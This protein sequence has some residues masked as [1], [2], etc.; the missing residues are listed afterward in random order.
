MRHTNVVLTVAAAALLAAC[1][2]SSDSPTTPTIKPGANI[3]SGNLQ[4]GRVT[5]ALAAPLVV[6]VADANGVPLTGQVVRFIIVSGG[7]LVDTDSTLTNSSGQATARWSLG[8]SV[9]DSQR[10]VAKLGA[11]RTTATTIGMFKATAQPGA[12]QLAAVSGGGQV[13]APSSVLTDSL[14]AR[15]ADQYGNPIAGVLVVWSTSGSGAGVLSPTQGTS[16]ANGYVRAKWTLGSA[17]GTQTASAASTGRTTVSFL[18][19]AQTVVVPPGLSMTV[20]SPLANALAGD[21]LLL[22]AAIT[23][24]YQLTSVRAVIGASTIN[25]TNN[26]N[27][28]WFSNIP[29]SSLPYGPQQVVVTVTDAQNS[30]VSK[31]VTFNHAVAPTIT[32]TAPTATAV[33]GPSIAIKASC[34]SLDETG[35]VSLEASV[36]GTTVASGLT[37][38]DA[39][40]SLAS[41]E[42]QLVTMTFKATDQVGLVRTATTTVNVYTN[43]LLQVYASVPGAVM[44]VNASRVFYW[45]NT[46][47][48][49]QARVQNGATTTTYFDHVGTATAIR[50][51]L[52]ANGAFFAVDTASG[53]YQLREYVSGAAR[54]FATYAAS[55]SIGWAFAGEWMAWTDATQTLYRRSIGG[56]TASTTT[57]AT[58]QFDINSNG[59]VAAAS[60][61]SSAVMSVTADG[62]KRTVDS[63]FVVTFSAVHLDLTRVL[64]N[65]Q[66]IC[67]INSGNMLRM[68]VGGG[69]IQTVAPYVVTAGGNLGPCCNAVNSGWYGFSKPSPTNELQVWAVSPAG[70]S[71]QVSNFAASSQ[72]EALGANG[73]VLFTSGSTR[74]YSLSPY[75]TV[76]SLGVSRG[77]PIYRDGRF[78]ILL[79]N[80]AY[81]IP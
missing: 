17:T 36:N 49:L 67:C 62:V 9:S 15:V 18:A 2:G 13:G 27:G 33:A 68:S 73:E 47:S 5:E 29:I 46:G 35:C 22:R 50:G 77:S 75:T 59:D 16:D 45:V 23:N 72:L 19:T 66:G 12:A 34:S 78:Y 8:T 71:T 1:R 32:I 26:G 28:V 20:T 42:G 38:I 64:W 40:V 57:T 25:L 65:Y 76:T 79:G 41:W 6:R 56:A 37:A 60:P 69:A 52:T 3:E 55:S 53:Q 21:T 70:T 30:E 31:S 81:R 14:A 51:F 7:G 43:P 80:T 63:D 54:T 58:S 10:V 74:Y 61:G 11:D 44:D 39:T 48:R 4:S 24:T